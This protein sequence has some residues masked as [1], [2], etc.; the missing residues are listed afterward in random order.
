MDPDPCPSPGGLGDPGCS[1]PAASCPQ[2]CF[3]EGHTTQSGYTASTPGDPEVAT[4]RNRFLQGVLRMRPLPSRR[5]G[6]R[7]SP[8]GKASQD[9]REDGLLPTLF[10]C[11]LPTVAHLLNF[12]HASCRSSSAYTERALSYLPCK[13][14]LTWWRAAPSS[15]FV[16]TGRRRAWQTH[17]SLP[18]IVPTRLLA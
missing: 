16:L 15:M 10:G 18:C 4:A 3:G 1:A 2:R 6:G 11:L 12:P 9:M 7:G 8:E 14:S 5:D 17:L 13:T